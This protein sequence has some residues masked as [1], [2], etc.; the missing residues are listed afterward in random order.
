[1][2]TGQKS[3]A[4]YLRL[5]QWSIIIPRL[6]PSL[7]GPA[8]LV[9]RA[10]HDI[11]TPRQLVELL[12]LFWYDQGI[13]D[14][15][16]FPRQLLRRNLNEDRIKYL[17]LRMAYLNLVYMQGLDEEDSGYCHVVEMRRP[18]QEYYYFLAAYQRF[19]NPDLHL[20]EAD[21]L[22]QYLGTVKN[23]VIESLLNLSNLVIFFPLGY[24]RDHSNDNRRFFTACYVYLLDDALASSFP[25]PEERYV[26]V[27]RDNNDAA[28]HE[29]NLGTFLIS[30]TKNLRGI[31]AEE[32]KQLDY[33]T[34][35]QLTSRMSGMTSCLADL[36]RCHRDY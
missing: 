30:L 9:C 16:H 17:S 12:Q 21:L 3:E 35:D 25:S 29:A 14:L 2:L 10:W 15:H 26:I 33:M 23:L 24:C 28:E 7:I 6:S 22:A 36:L 1:M 18:H 27:E 32:E 8:R 5:M 31:A 4:A 13:Y 19:P 20:Y 11:A 34:I